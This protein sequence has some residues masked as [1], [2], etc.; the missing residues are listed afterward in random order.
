MG[1]PIAILKGEGRILINKLHAETGRLADILIVKMLV[2]QAQK[3][4]SAEI[5]SE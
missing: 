4:L 3:E 5:L 2:L 1:G